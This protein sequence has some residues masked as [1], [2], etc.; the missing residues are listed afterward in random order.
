MRGKLI[1]ALGLLI[2]GAAALA[3]AQEGQAIIARP[4]PGD[5]V[6]GEV[7][8]VGTATH[9]EFRRYQLEFATADQ[10]DVW[11]PIQEPVSQQIS[12]GV[13]G[14]WN[15]MAGLPDGVY[16]LRLRVFLRNGASFET[17]VDELHVTNTQ[18]T[19]VPTAV[20]QPTSPRVTPSP[21]LGPSPTPLIWQPPSVTPRAAAG[22]SAPP[23]RPAA[24]GAGPSLA[25]WQAA[26]CNGIYLTLALFALL[27]FY[28]GVR[29]SLRPWLRRQW[30]NFR[31]G[32]R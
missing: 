13:L 4:A 8:I 2:L 15:T 10:P 11:L 27:V 12:D 14:V 25:Q 22:G 3:S 18:P 32:M 1:L 29:T 7:Q 16:R 6:F 28:L 26:C 21:T 30:R 20:P 17:V 31:R 9:P 23:S 19:P 24:D 5:R